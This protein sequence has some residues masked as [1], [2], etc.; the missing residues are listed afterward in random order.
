M[1]QTIVETQAAS[2]N[3]LD[4]YIA[5]TPGVC[6]GRP[7]VSGHRITVYDIVVWRNQLGMAFEEIAAEY[8]LSLASVYAAMAYYYD[9][10][11]EIDQRA[12]DDHGIAAE[13][14]RHHPSRIQEKL[15]Q[16]STKQIPVA[17]LA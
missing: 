1:L 12:E 14:Q 3:G 15:H 7:R 16:Q 10:K 6:G 13:F 5:I 11:T 17:D 8:D 9:H 2:S 4:Q